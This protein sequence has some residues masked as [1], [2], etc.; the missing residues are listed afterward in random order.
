MVGMMLVVG[1]ASVSWVHGTN[2]VI[3]SFSGNGVLRWASDLTNASYE[4]QWASALT[5]PDWTNSW[6]GLVDLTPTGSTATATVPM[7]YRVVAQQPRTYHFPDYYPSDPNVYKRRVFEVTNFVTSSGY[8]VT[9]AITGF[10]TVPYKTGAIVGVTNLFGNVF[11][12]DG[13]VLR[14]LGGGGGFYSSDTN[15]TAYS[16]FPSFGKV[17]DGMVVQDSG[18]WV[19]E[20]LSEYEGEL[21]DAGLVEIQTVTLPGGV[22]TN[23]I[24]FWS[25]D[26]SWPF[27]ALDFHGIESE[28]GITLPT[29]EKLQ[30][31]A[32]F[33][34]TVF[35]RG[36]GM[37]AYGSIEDQSTSGELSEM[38]TLRATLA[39]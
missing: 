13:N 24:I 22:F 19:K 21:G 5:S 10:K 30:G 8:E 37:V 14:I 26:D 25:F 27:R 11:Y 23:A 15:L 16:G 36:V 7:F 1:L 12:N 29:A 20:D 6:K 4:V 32:L 9:N 35:A 31:G 38:Y 33:Q 2:V 17:Y 39:P 3:T 28:M 34:M 18:Y